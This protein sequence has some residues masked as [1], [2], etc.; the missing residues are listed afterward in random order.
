MNRRSIFIA[1]TL[2]AVLFVIIPMVAAVPNEVSSFG[3]EAGCK[4]LIVRTLNEENV[5]LAASNTMF[6]VSAAGVFEGCW[7][8]WPAGPCRAIYR[9][10]RSYTICGVCDSSGNPGSGGCSPIS[11]STLNQGY[12][13]S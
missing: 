9:Q 3:P 4:T 2:F 7:T 13:C 10:N 12:W 6:T 1:A 11:L 5:F 8:Y